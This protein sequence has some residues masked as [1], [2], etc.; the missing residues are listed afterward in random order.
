MKYKEPKFINI[1]QL[2]QQLNSSSL[3]V[4][5]DALLQIFMNNIDLTLA[6]YWLKKCLNDNN[7][8]ILRIGILGASHIVRIY[9]QAPV[10]EIRKLLSNIK[11]IELQGTIEDTLDDLEIYGHHHD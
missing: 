4:K 3:D 10:E 11:S 6:M 5:I 1:N 9:D 8:E 2:T 7:K